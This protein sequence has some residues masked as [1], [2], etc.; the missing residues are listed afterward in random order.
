MSKCCCCH[1]TPVSPLKAAQEALRKDRQVA[2]QSLVEATRK[3]LSPNDTGHSMG[4]DLAL[5]RVLAAFGLK[6]K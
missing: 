3:E 1:A 5:S 6:P 2:I 4:V